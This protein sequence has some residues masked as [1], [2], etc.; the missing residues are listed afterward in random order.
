MKLVNANGG[1]AGVGSRDAGKRVYGQ[2]DR[3]VQ[4]VGMGERRRVC[5]EDRVLINV[6]DLIR[7]GAL[8]LSFL[9]LAYV[10][11][12]KEREGYNMIEQRNGLQKRDIRGRCR[13]RRKETAALYLVS[14]S[15]SLNMHHTIPWKYGIEDRQ[16]RH[17]RASISTEIN[18][19]KQQDTH[20]YSV[21]IDGPLIKISKKSLKDCMYV[22]LCV[23]DVL[24]IMGERVD[25][26]LWWKLNRTGGN[27]EKKGIG[28]IKWL[29]QQKGI[30]DGEEA[31]LGRRGRRER[32][33]QRNHCEEV[34]S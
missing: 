13:R 34:P 6:S 1:K 27:E 16:L 22:L 24:C 17:P 20:V 2:K 4:R 19:N 8:L 21:D 15:L 25:C 29:L 7:N 33:Q 11:G 9:F 10:A 26:F 23:G 30:S 31:H 3:S 18:N 28:V 14:L 32:E 12:A 5:G